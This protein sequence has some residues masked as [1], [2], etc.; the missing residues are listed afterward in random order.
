[1]LNIIKAHAVHFEE[2]IVISEQKEEEMSLPE[3]EPKE[4]TEDEAISAEYE[5]RL[6]AVQKQ[7]DDMMEDARIAAEELIRKAQSEADEI[8]KQAEID[9]KALKA[10]SQ[11][12]GFREGA[13]KGYS[14]SLAKYQLLIEKA[15][16]IIGDA[17]RYKADTVNSMEGEIVELI[18]ACVEKITRKILG[19]NDEVL[20]NL[21]R[22]AIDS[23]THRDHISIKINREDYNYIDMTKERILAQ[24]PGIRSIDIRIDDGMKKGDLEVESESGTV[25]PSIS[26]QIKK[27]VQEFDKLFA[28]EELI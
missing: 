12:S 11:E 1:M 16:T 5:F 3:E 14:E 4:I 9:S 10:D 17:E 6:Q 2:H 24:F 26:K 21:I 19:E 13:E 18:T 8:R 22:T 27:L 20:L 15:Q 7:C 23:L 25:N 28:N